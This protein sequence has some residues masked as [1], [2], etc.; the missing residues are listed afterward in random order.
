[1]VITALINISLK[2]IIRRERPYDEHPTI[3]WLVEGGSYSF[4]SGHSAE[5]FSLMMGIFL[6]IKNPYLKFFIAIWAIFIGYTRMAM[7]VHYPLDVLGGATLG[8]SVAYLW[9]KKVGFLKK[10]KS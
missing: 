2:F 10:Y 4:P 6:L 3:K 1:L 7:G 5:V 9:V 8:A